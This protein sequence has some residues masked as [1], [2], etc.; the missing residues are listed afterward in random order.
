M[1]QIKYGSEVSGKAGLWNN[2]RWMGGQI[3][4]IA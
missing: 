3:V 1:E 2:E 4:V